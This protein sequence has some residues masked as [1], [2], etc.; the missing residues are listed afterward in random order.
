M[1]F[2]ICL[3]FLVNLVVINTSCTTCH[4]YDHPGT[5]PI[6]FMLVDPAGKNLAGSTNSLY[7]PDSIRV[8]LVGPQMQ[9][10]KLEKEFDQSTNGYKFYFFPAYYD[11]SY[12]IYLNKMDT[13]TL[14]VSYSLQDTKCFTIVHYKDFLFNNKTIVQSPA[15]D[16]H[17]V[18]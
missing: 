10:L 8:S 5:G 13:D 7:H 16:L 3:V 11:S 14:A 1:K 17:F 6:R 18:E 9:E 12:Y 4:D 2:L 15:F